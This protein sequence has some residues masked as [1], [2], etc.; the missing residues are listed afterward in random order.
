MRYMRLWLIRAWVVG[1]K[2]QIVLMALLW[3]SLVKWLVFQS[4]K[5]SGCVAFHSNFSKNHHLKC[6]TVSL[7]RYCL[8]I[9]V[10][11]GIAGVFAPHLVPYSLPFIKV[12][13]PPLF[14]LQ[15]NHWVYM[16]MIFYNSYYKHAFISSDG[17]IS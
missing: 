9:S 8:K 12:T 10:A 14:S 3:Q 16:L 17:Y 15:F 4:T 13:V 6:I 7:E 11:H 2:I 5:K 1:S